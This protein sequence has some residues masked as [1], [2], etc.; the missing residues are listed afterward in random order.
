MLQQYISVEHSKAVGGDN[1]QGP[2]YNL[3][4]SLGKQA[5]SI[6]ETPASYRYEWPKESISIAGRLLPNSAEIEERIEELVLEL[7]GICEL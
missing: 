1:S 2:I 6:K 3:N 5:D 4:S 7:Q